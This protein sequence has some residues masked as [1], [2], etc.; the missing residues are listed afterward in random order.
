LVQSSAT[1]NTICPEDPIWA[2]VASICHLPSACQAFLSWWETDK[3][4]P[5]TRS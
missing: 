2:P 3:G 4:T 1:D 5:D